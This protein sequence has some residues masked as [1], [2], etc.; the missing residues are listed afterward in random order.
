MNARGGV[1]NANAARQPDVVHVLLVAPRVRDLHGDVAVG[2]TRRLDVERQNGTLRRRRRRR[3]WQAHRRARAHARAEL[4]KVVVDA[5]RGRGAAMPSGRAPDMS[6]DAS[7]P[8]PRWR[9]LGVDL[10]GG[11]EPA[12]LANP[13]LRSEPPSR[14]PFT[15]AV[16]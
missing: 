10:G 13:S 6:S 15:T 2:Q 4:E 16:R 11:Y 1:R 3:L 14:P 5:D 8:Q 9:S 12:R 7:G